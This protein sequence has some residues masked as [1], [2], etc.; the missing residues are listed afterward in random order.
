MPTTKKPA[1]T[2]SFSAFPGFEPVSSFSSKGTTLAPQAVMDFMNMMGGNMNPGAQGF[3]GAPSFEQYQTGIMR[4][5]AEANR[6]NQANFDR[7]TGIANQVLAA[8]KATAQQLRDYQNPFFDQ[9]SK[10]Q[11]DLLK[12]TQADRNTFDQQAK[13][14]QRK[15][16]QQTNQVAGTFN[17]A[18]GQIDQGRDRIASEMAAGMRQNYDLQREQ[19]QGAMGTQGIS[20][21]Q[22]AEAQRESKSEMER[23]VG[24]NVS[25]IQFQGAQAKAGILQAK[26][27]TLAS[28]AS[29]T[30]SLN[31]SL[32][33]MGMDQ[34]KAV[35]GAIKLG[36]DTAMYRGQDLAQRMD[37]A[38][39]LET[40]G[41]NNWAEA[42]YKNP[43]MGVNILPS[44]LA[45][46][47]A[48]QLTGGPANA[49]A[50]QAK[51]LQEVRSA[52]NNLTA[53]GYGN[54]GMNF[55]I[56]RMIMNGTSVP[57]ISQETAQ[58]IRENGMPGDTIYGALGGAG[59]S[60]YA[61]GTA[62]RGLQATVGQDTSYGRGGFNQGLNT[63]IG[64]SGRPANPFSERAG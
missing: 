9:A 40:A 10:I 38:A 47:Q 22:I 28:L 7:N 11:G 53:G 39:R 46:G 14:A 4:D 57:G 26:A 20:Q 23:G 15:L 55:D 64:S 29:T 32:M 54:Y 35:Q 61:E 19:M 41:Y 33:S 36:F 51:A 30:A 25:N 31:T 24:A 18:M 3:K 45:V 60:G 62:P 16:D 17:Q 1:S 56:K 48:A 37:T 44:L 43:V 8:N 42:M 59:Q 58:W 5:F 13:A 27:G 12:Q 21:D 49:S 52:Q 50:M 63:D 2:G 34:A 6:V